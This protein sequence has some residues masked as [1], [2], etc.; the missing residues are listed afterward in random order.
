MN[1]SEVMTRSPIVA[2]P[3]ESVRQLVQ[4]FEK[5]EFHHLPVVEHG[6]LLGI[7]SDRDVLRHVS[8]FVGMINE[9]QQDVSTLERRAHQVMTRRPMTIEPETS[10][11]EAA[12][13][14]LEHRVSCLPVVDSEGRLF[15]IVTTRDLLRVAYG[16][17]G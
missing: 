10:V 2:S 7:I 1:V 11:E 4:L 15:G 8:P 3:D 9:Q 5:H 6:R 12:A 14:M 17:A 16:E 13:A